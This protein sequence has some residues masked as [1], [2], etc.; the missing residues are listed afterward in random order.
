MGE[1]YELTKADFVFHDIELWYQGAREAMSCLRCRQGLEASG[2]DLE[3]YLGDLGAEM[4]RDLYLE[5]TERS[6]RMGVEPPLMGKYD[7][8]AQRP[9]YMQVL[10]FNKMYPDWIDLAQPSL[11]VGGDASYIREIIRENYLL[12][13]ERRT[14]PWL[15]AGTYGEF[16][17]SKIEHMLL[18]AMLNGAG[19][20]TYYCFE[21]FDGPM[22]YYYH[23]SALAHLAPYQK[24]LAEG[25]ILAFEGDNP[26][27]SYSAW[28]TEDEM[29]ILIGNYQNSPRVGTT[30]QLQQQV[31]RVVNVR[32]KTEKSIP[33]DF[34]LKVSV[35][36][37]EI[38]LLY[39]SAA[40]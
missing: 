14:I 28:G 29:L 12:I 35:N 8:H 16:E 38:L 20:I 24:L 36:P 19:G 40:H 25:D 31:N 21:N 2:K 17:P 33:R 3:N 10:D 5:I 32:E 7:V 39:I 9:V 23:A 18:E 22:D 4:A 15:T 1:L 11:Y 34:A 13:G 37:Q 30:L 27:L 6:R 26:D